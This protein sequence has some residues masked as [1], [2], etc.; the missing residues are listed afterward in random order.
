MRS[1][2]TRMSQCRRVPMPNLLRNSGIIKS[3]S[4]AISG[5]GGPVSERN[6]T[7]GANA[8]SQ[9]EQNTTPNGGTASKTFTAAAVISCPSGTQQFRLKNTHGAV[10]DNFSSNFTATTT[11][12]LFVYAVTN[13]SNQGNNAQIFGVVNSTAGAGGGVVTVHST[14]MI[15]G[16]FTAQQIIDRGGIPLTY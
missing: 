15:E 12:T 6:F 16:S 11:P 8:L 3:S 2:A 10:S 13:G 4:W 14:L 1:K 5:G 9:V 7:F